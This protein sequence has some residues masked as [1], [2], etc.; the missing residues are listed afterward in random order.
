MKKP[1]L[2]LILKTFIFTF[3]L[4]A[5][6]S[7]SS[8]A[9][10]NKEGKSDSTVVAAPS[11]ITESISDSTVQFLISSAAGDFRNYKQ[12]T[13]VDFRKVKV[14]YLEL[15][16]GVKTFVLCSEFVA[17]EKKDEWL[18]FA[19]LKTSN[20]EQYMGNQALSFCEKATIV[21]TDE[22]GLSAELK[23]KLEELRK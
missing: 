22:T 2:S 7:C 9:D 13:P 21:L 6:L 11:E 23:N 20:Y 16:P 3:S 10:N 4:S 1:N 19:T 18:P 12:V 15:T 17:K 5:I 8:N 14:G